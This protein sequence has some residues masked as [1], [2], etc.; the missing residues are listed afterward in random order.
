MQINQI[1]IQ[2]QQKKDLHRQQNVKE[3]LPLYDHRNSVFSIK[4]PEIPHKRASIGNVMHLTSL[5][6]CCMV[7]K[8]KLFDSTIHGCGMIFRSEHWVI[9]IMWIIFGL[10]SLAYLVYLMSTTLIEYY[11]FAVTVSISTYQDLPAVFPAV[12]ICNINPFN[13]KYSY[14]YI[15]NKTSKAACFKLPTGDAFSACMNST[16]TN[17]AFDKFNEQMKR[18]VANDKTLSEWDYYWYGYDLA[19]VKI[20]DFIFI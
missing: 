20:I 5:Q 7:A 14:S 19:T 1:Q 11:K 18:V 8:Q 17:S 15:L 4:M 12:T 16:N 13:E 3:K 10:G 6:L 2:G 9:R